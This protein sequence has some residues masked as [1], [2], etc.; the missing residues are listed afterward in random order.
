ML[1]GLCVLEAHLERNVTL[2]R[3]MK[4]RKA[5]LMV[6]KRRGGSEQHLRWPVVYTETGMCDGA[7]TGVT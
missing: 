7:A 4:K 2:R 1:C 5:V 6:E 3:Q